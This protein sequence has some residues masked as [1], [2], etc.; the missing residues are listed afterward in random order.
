MTGNDPNATGKKP[1][2]LLFSDDSTLIFARRMREELQKADSLRPVEMIHF[3]DENA[4]SPRQLDQLLPEGPDCVM[5]GPDLAAALSTEGRDAI[6]TSR[7]YAALDEALRTLPERKSLNRPC[8]VAFL[9]G[10]DFFPEQGFVRRRSCDAVY[11]FPQSAILDFRRLIEPPEDRWQ[12]LGFG[13]PAALMPEATGGETSRDIFFF[14]QA[15]SPSTKRGRVHMLRIMIALA[16]AYPDRTIWIKLR[17][18]PDENRNHLHRERHDYP[19]LLNGMGPLPA[20]LRLTDMTMEEALEQTGLGITCTSTAALDLVRAG[21]PCIVHLDFVDAYVDPLVPPMRRLFA[22]S[23]LIIPLED[24]LELRASP[25]DPDWL[26]DMFCPRDLG[27]HVLDT[28][29]RFHAKDRS[30]IK[31]RPPVAAQQEQAEE[32]GHQ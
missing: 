32:G 23:G 18:L 27:R 25:P 11:L 17:H 7:V 28:I 2:S 19:A 24:L 22:A 30:Q 13:H 15:L 31:D 21:R 10:L 20:N 1:L 14:T 26:A 4:L 29:A 5:T 3:T 12:E 6:V 8:V 16:R 9:G